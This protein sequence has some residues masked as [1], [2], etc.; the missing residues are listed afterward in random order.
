MTGIYAWRGAAM[1]GKGAP[2][3]ISPKG[4]I[5]DGAFR[6]IAAYRRRRGA[7]AVASTSPSLPPIRREPQ[8][9][10]LDRS[11]AV[12]GVRGGRYAPPVDIARLPAYVPAAFVAIEDRRFYEHQGFDAVGIARAWSPTW[13]R[14]APPRAPRPSPSSWPA[15]S[16]SPPTGPSSA[17]PRSWSTP[18]SW[19]RPTPSSR[20]SASISAG[21]ISAPAPMASRRPPTATSTSRPRR[22]THARGGDAGG[23][24]EVADR[25]R[26]GRRSRSARPSAR[27][28]VLDAMVETGAITPA[29]RARALAQ[30]PKVWREAPGRARA[31]FRRLGGRARRRQM[32]GA[33]RS[34]T[35]WSRPPWTCRRDGRRR[36]GRRRRSRRYA[37]A[38]RRARPA[39]VALDG[40]GRVRA[41][42][43]R[44]RLRRP[45]R[46]TARSTPTARPARR[47]S[48]SSIW[49]RWRPGQTPDTRWSTSR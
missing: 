24:D 34:R 11:G 45:A 33:S 40:Q 49:R 17:R 7:R 12:L 30:T 28:L 2:G 25:L 41:P 6:L 42:D 15:T 47:G 14:A 16:S 8:I 20:S 23:A 44:R 48:R 9:T 38:G 3:R 37:R 43:R 10:Y 5:E 1:A 31:V 4:R 36:G 18:S 13:A 21:S 19:S 26:P 35:W 39:L 22:L 46:S 27:A 29:Q 32:V